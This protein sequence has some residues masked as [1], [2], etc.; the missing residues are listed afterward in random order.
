MSN[1][2]HNKLH[3]E[4]HHSDPT[5]GFPDSSYDPIASYEAPWKGEFYS[6]G[7]IATT[8][9]LSAAQRVYALGGN[10][11]QWNSVYSTVTSTSGNWNSVYSTVQA[12]S[13]VWDASIDGSGAIGSLPKFTGT[14]TLGDSV[15]YENGS[16]IRIGS[17]PLSADLNVYGSYLQ[18]VNG[19][20]HYVIR[21]QDGTGRVNHYW[22]T[23]G[24]IGATYSY[25][26][27][28]AVRILCGAAGQNMFEVFS[29][30]FTS[31]TTSTAGQVIPW[32]SAFAVSP[33]GKVGI[34][35]STPSTQLDVNGDYYVYGNGRIDGD[36]TIFGKLSTLG[37]L[38]YLDTILT[39][40]SAISVVNIGGP[41]PA[42]TV[43]QTGPAPVA[44]FLDEGN[45]ALFIAG[46]GAAP[47][48][49]GIKTD[50]PKTS[51]HINATDGLV[52]PVGTDVQRVNQQG[53]IRFNTTQA[54]FEGYN[55][56]SWGPLGGG[57]TDKDLD[58]YI[59]PEDPANG[60]N[61]ELKF[62]TAG[63]ERV[64][65]TSDGL[66]MQSGAITPTVGSGETNGIMF[67]KDPFFGAGDTAFIRYQQD[68]GEDTAFVFGTTNDFKDRLT[69]QQQGVNLVNLAYGRV[70]INRIPNAAANEMLSVNGNVN[71]ID[72]TNAA[73][74]TTFTGEVT[75][76]GAANTVTA[77]ND[78]LKVVVNGTT[79][80]IRLFDIT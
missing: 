1:R 36:L 5:A 3:R 62:F 31:P 63:T 11:S 7:L 78:F 43:S 24:G 25:S 20:A 9:D 53:A 26:N 18:T 52:I 56:A 38:S 2:F 22:N 72:T 27:E 16:K 34:R 48:F 15:I 37:S 45:V 71:I 47:G 51:F 40:T 46:T 79:R 44:Q 80:Y 23:M 42:L 28:G 17:A 6:T 55:G 58:T 67:P 76:A 10:S 66:I 60:D 8:Q 64:R 4:N 57:L 39:T 41:V 33:Y 68:A 50:D 59:T 65:I 12:N 19:D 32:N 29:S 75:T 77:R 14:S 21:V 54:A 73:N 13:A 49:V 69:L 61:D 70:G 74:S 35:T 30:S